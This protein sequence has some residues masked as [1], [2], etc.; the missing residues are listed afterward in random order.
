MGNETVARATPAVT[1]G[2]P[3]VTATIAI[4]VCLAMPD[5]AWLVQLDL[6]PGATVAEALAASGL[7]QRVGDLDLAHAAVGI[8][9]KRVVRT[10]KLVAGDRVE[11]YRP[12]TYDPKDSRRRRAQHRQRLRAADFSA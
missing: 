11:I 2:A 9:G 5:R 6:V 3:S 12:L 7:E 1:S 4:S 10:R 8:F